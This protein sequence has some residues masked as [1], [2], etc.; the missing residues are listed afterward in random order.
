MQGN[1][2]SI[3][4]RSAAADALLS[5]FGHQQ[6]PPHPLASTFEGHALSKMAYL[7]GAAI[8]QPLPHENDMMVRARGLTSSDFSAVVATAGRVF[9][10]ARYRA[11][12]RHLAFCE[13]VEV[14]NFK[15]ESVGDLAVANELPLVGEGAEITAHRALL[16]DGGITAALMSYASILKYSR[17]VVINDNARLVAS[18]LAAFGNAAARTEARLVYQ[19]LESNPVMP[20]G[21]PAFH[22]DFGNIVVPTEGSA[23]L[24]EEILGAGLSALRKGAS[25][26]RNDGD[27]ADLDAAHL[28]VSAELEFTARKLASSAS[29]PIDIVATTRITAGRWYLLPDRSVQP[30]VAALRLKGAASPLRLEQ[31]TKSAGFDG[32]GVRAA[33]DLGAALVSRFAVRGGA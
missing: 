28:I 26:L 6:R 23:A 17:D 1:T 9:A 27:V 7:V 18:S 4:M 11:A 14:R 16:A 10:E 5:E 22:E 20:D 19:A 21:A 13:S 12:A 2:F 32:F 33:A 24:G 25:L 3:D 8:R 15:P 29:M 30:V 31:A